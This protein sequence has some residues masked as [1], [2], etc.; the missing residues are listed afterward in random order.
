VLRILLPRMLDDMF[1]LT[2]DRAFP[3]PKESGLMAKTLGFRAGAS[4]QNTNKKG[5]ASEN[6]N[7]PI[8]TI[9]N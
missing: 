9:Y 2:I 3:N 6:I 7:S 1:K 8:Q 5:N 4:S